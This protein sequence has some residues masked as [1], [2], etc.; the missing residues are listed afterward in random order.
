MVKN[1]FKMEYYIK[2]YMDD[3][4]IFKYKLSSADK[5]REHAAAIIKDGYRHNDGKIFEHYPPH[6]ILKVKSE[7]IPTNYTDTVEGT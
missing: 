4:R 6:R 1:L 3:G 5:V 2:I 7:N